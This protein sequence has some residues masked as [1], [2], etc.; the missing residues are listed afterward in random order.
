MDF[1]FEDIISDVGG[2]MEAAGVVVIVLG[3]AIATVRFVAALRAAGGADGYTTYRRDLGRALLLGLEFL[4][5][6]DIIRTVAASPSLEDVAVLGGIVLIRSFLSF[7][8]E[9]E[10]EGR[11]PWQRR[12]GPPRDDATPVGR[13]PPPG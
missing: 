7:A 12:A 1:N 4:V 5:A 10:T 2:A 6:G 3:A 8:L 11:W 13:R 9:L